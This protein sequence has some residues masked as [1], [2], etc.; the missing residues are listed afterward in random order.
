MKQSQ[1]PGGRIDYIDTGQGVPFLWIHGFPLSSAVFESQLEIGGVRH[2]VPDLP[3]FGNSPHQPSLAIDDYA[4]RLLALLDDLGVDTAVVGGLSMGGYIALALARLE[5]RRLRALVLIDSR[6]VP[7]TPEGRENRWK[8]IETVKNEGTTQLI[9][10][11]LPKMLSP[12]TLAAA[13][14]ESRKVRA[15]MESASKEGVMTA[16]A[17]MAVRGDSSA[18]LRDL[19]VPLLVTVGDEDTITSVED[20]QRM[21]SLARIASIEIIP[22]AAHLS[23]LER[24]REFNQAVSGFLRRHGILSGEGR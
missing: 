6:E 23:N 2:I 24:P 21:Q 9:E 16:L 12:R 4:K 8:Q 5:P 13:G 11:M 14:E 22:G 7:D 3:G 17:A 10:Q 18:A 20:A 1:A 15:I 19:D